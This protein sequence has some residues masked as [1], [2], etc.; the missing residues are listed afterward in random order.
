MISGKGIIDTKTLYPSSKST[1]ISFSATALMIPE[2]QVLVYYIHPTG[3]VIYDTVAV[4][5]QMRFQNEVNN[6]YCEQVK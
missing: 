5:I 4:K 2:V 1:E 6:T 3:E